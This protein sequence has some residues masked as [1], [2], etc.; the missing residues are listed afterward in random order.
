MTPEE[1]DVFLESV[2]RLIEAGKKI[3]E[4]LSADLAAVCEALQLVVEEIA[5]SITETI[6]P[7][8]DTVV[9][10]LIKER[11]REASRRRPEPYAAKPR[12]PFRKRLKIFRCR[13][14]C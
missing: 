6:A 1:K 12:P 4:K 14:S 13:N 10:E 8:I 11:S 5:E 7:I 2:Q 9:D 3:V